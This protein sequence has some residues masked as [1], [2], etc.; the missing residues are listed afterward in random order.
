MGEQRQPLASDYLPS[1]VGRDKSTGFDMFGSGGD[2]WLRSTH[3]YVWM[4][5]K[6]KET[7]LT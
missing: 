4:L 2:G 7:R 3:Q 1:G 6:K 5:R